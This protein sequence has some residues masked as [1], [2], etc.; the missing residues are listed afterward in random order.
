MWN[1]WDFSVCLIKS[2]FF[3]HC[4]TMKQNHLSFNQIFSEN[5]LIHRWFLSL[6][7]SE[8]SKRK[9]FPWSLGSHLPLFSFPWISWYQEYC[10]KY[11]VFYIY[12]DKQVS[13]LCFLLNRMINSFSFIYWLQPD[14]LDKLENANF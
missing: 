6:F 3:F 1:G 9:I 12:G 2:D 8:S 5:I 13:L 11:E 14:C 7:S 10:C 4:R